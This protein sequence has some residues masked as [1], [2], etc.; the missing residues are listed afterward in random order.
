M[1]AFLGKSRAL[2]KDN[3]MNKSKM[4]NWIAVKL[5]HKILIAINLYR[6]PTTLSNRNKCF[7]TQ[8]NLLN[9][10]TKSASTYQKEIFHQIKIYIKKNDNITDIIIAGDFNQ[11]IASK[12]IQ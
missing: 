1:S 6:I 5:S 9:G 8:C 12:H 4:G 7:L 2:I 10:K 3:E 11:N